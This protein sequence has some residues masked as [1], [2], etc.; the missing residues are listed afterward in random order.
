MQIQYDPT[1]DA[2]ISLHGVS[3]DLLCECHFY[4]RQD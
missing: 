3:F 4:T 1:L 2:L